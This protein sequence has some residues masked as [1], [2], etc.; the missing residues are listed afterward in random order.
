MNTMYANWMAICENLMYCHDDCTSL[1]H[2]G[3]TKD[4]D[5]AYWFEPRDSYIKK[6]K[7]SDEKWF[8]GESD[9][10]MLN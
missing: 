6:F 5:N 3:I 1:I 7:A 2:D 10:L 9:A 4:Q 8:Q